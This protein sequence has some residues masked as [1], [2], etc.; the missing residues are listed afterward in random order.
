MTSNLHGPY[1]W[2]YTHNTMANTNRSEAATR[3]QS[4]K[5]RLSSDWSLQL[6]SMKPESLVT[7]ISHGTL[8][9][10]LG[11]VLTARQGMEAGDA[12]SL[13]NNCGLR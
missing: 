9:M 12:Q 8:N 7:Y 10:F 1:A 5:V 11:L 3:S 13:Q 6:D 4:E 2:G